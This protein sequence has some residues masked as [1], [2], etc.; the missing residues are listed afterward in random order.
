MG[1]PGIFAAVAVALALVAFGLVAAASRPHEAPPRLLSMTDAAQALIGDGNVV[2]A[3]GQA[4]LDEAAQ[5]GDSD[6][7]YHGQHWLQTGQDMVQRGQWMEMDPLA[8]GNLVTSPA[9]LSRQG[10]WGSLPQTAEAMMRD[11]SHAGAEDL[12]AL[13]WNGQAMLAEGRIMAGQGELLTSEADAMIAR[14]ALQGADAAAVHHAAQTLHDVGS[15]L[16]QNG[17]QMVD[18]ADRLRQSLGEYP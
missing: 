14:H 15:D 18:Y 3:H 10:A 1:K 8:P 16:Q 17:Q 4:M 11:P 2:Q 5:T 6:L 12:Q 7:Q 13:R 9:D